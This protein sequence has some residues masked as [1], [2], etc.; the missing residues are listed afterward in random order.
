MA[1]KHTDHFS[2]ITCQYRKDSVFCGLRENELAKIDSHKGHITYNK[3]EEIFIEGDRPHGI[4][5]IHGGKVKLSKHGEFG[6]EQIVR[7]A[8]ESDVI[9]YRALLGNEM[10]DCS[11][12]ALEQTEVCFVPKSDFFE[13]FDNSASLSGNMVKLLT[14]D[15]KRAENKLTDIAQKPVRER[16]AETIL[17]L[18][19]TFGEDIETGCIKVVLSRE[20]I[21]NMAGT[22]T[23]TAI[24]LLSELKTDALIEFVGKKLKSLIKKNCFE[25]QIFIINNA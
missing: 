23:E 17:V 10:Y 22:A 21:A 13:I 24:R 15:L 2:C 25:E 4:Y 7:F 19:E 1:K 8:K 20:E 14:L 12:V 16:I 11:A 5:C 9:G 3:G 6:K 18:K